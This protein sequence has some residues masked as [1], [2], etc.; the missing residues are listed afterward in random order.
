M[1]DVV[2]AERMISECITA[3][4]SQQLP[5]SAAVDAILHERIDAE[6][7]QPPFDR[8]TMDGI[9]IAFRDWQTGTRSF[10]VIGTQR[11]GVPP[12]T[13]S[14]P[15]QC[16]EVMTG[17]VLPRNADCVIPVERIS[18][19]GE[20]AELLKTAQASVGQFIHPRGS[21]RKKGS[22]LLHPGTRLTPP[23]IAIAAS[24]GQ[25]SIKTAKLPHVAIVSTGDE[26]VGVDEAI[27]YFQI[28]SSNDRAIEACL[29]RHH[30]AHVSRS[31]LKDE[32]GKMLDAIRDL[33][34]KHDVLILSGGVSMGQ[35]D[36]VPS[37]LEELGVELVF[38]KI[39]QRPGRPM[40][41]GVSR[42]KKPVFALPG[43]PVSTMV[44]LRRYVIPALHQA[45]G[46]NTERPELVFL[47]DNVEFSAD[48]TYFLPVVVGWA[49][50]GRAMAEP[51]PTNTSGDFV[52]LA[53]TDG[54]VE[55]PRGEDQFERG[56][57]VRLF[58]W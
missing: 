20:Y 4:G 55:L 15:G 12:L 14:E 1:T 35:F 58:R 44:C 11:A 2:D 21:D 31:Q 29:I 56:R 25:A 37:V 8:V 27:E 22:P 19:V 33:H 39:E 24:A 13:L 32:R 51:R 38:H 49:D 50:D 53:G 48:L 45:L 16:A 23:E 42:D 34:A 47:A 10:Q 28:R 9:A 43:N 7:D 18:R 6:R 26:L 40:W 52:S 5:L 30:A 36:F 54:F 3:F 46:L 41:F 17:A 57:V